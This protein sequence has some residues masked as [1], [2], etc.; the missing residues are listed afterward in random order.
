MQKLKDIINSCGEKNIKTHIRINGVDMG[1]TDFYS[2]EELMEKYSEN[3]AEIV[4]YEK[5]Y[6]DG[7]IAIRRYLAI[8]VYEN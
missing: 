1:I 4:E 6:G 3:N 8:D 5:D 7:A 2:R